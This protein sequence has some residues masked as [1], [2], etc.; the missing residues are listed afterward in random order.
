M[1]FAGGRAALSREAQLRAM[2]A[3]I[4]GA[5]TGD[6]LTTTGSTVESDRQLAADAGLEF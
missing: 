1:R 2:R 6:M 4:N 5:I 3:G